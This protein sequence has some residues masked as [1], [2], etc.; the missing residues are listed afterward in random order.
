MNNCGIS[1]N[2][3][4]SILTTRIFD[5]V[6]IELDRRSLILKTGISPN[7][8]CAM[9]A[10]GTGTLVPDSNITVSPNLNGRFQDINGT[11]CLN[12]CLTYI[13]E[14]ARST[15][16]CNLLLPVSLRMSLPDEAIWPYDITVHYSY[17]ADNLTETEN[18]YNAICDGVA[19]VYITSLMPV[20]LRDGSSF[21]YNT[22]CERTIVNDNTFT[23]SRFYPA[24][25]VH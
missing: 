13:F 11:L 12:G 22:E 6:R 10:N 3:G 5:N 18:G 25:S 4:I 16:P 7:S 23:S 24:D 1:D 14:G 20:T 8:V 15:A 21:F 9:Y 2:N 17:F 19:I